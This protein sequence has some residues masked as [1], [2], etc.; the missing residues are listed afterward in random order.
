[1]VAGMLM[2]HGMSRPAAVRGI[3]SAAAL[4]AAT[5]CVPLPNPGLPASVPRPSLGQG[6]TDDLGRLGS[7]L[8]LAMPDT[9]VL[10]VPAESG[11]CGQSNVRVVRSVFPE[12]VLFATASDEPAPG[13]AGILNVLADR[14]RH[15]APGSDVT[16]LGHTD[17]VGSDAYNMDLSRRRA[18]RVL[19]ILAAGGLDPDHLSAVAIG[20]RQ[21]VADNASADGRA[22]NRRVE[23]LISGCLAANLGVVRGQAS[24]AGDS[25]SPVDLMRLDPSAAYGLATAGTISLR[26]ASDDGTV[27]ATVAPAPSMQP[28]GLQPPARVA[29]PTPAPHYQP[30]TLSPDAQ[31]NPLGPAV[32]F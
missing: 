30:N 21:P 9:G 31:P 12:R 6:S 29:R 32:P 23:F 22:R 27:P 3:V 14:V 17:A 7:D 24:S 1:M 28:P 16:V 8:T 19:R 26:R 20:S 11:T 25:S 18:L 15:D 2:P 13:A 10:T 5:A 4:S